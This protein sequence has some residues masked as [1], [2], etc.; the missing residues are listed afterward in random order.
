MGVDA[1]STGQHTMAGEHDHAEAQKPFRFEQLLNAFERIRYDEPGGGADGF[2][3]P[4]PYLHD[5][6][7]ALTAV[8]HMFEHLGSA[9]LFVKRDVL[10]KRDT[11]HAVFAADPA[12]HETV[13]Q[14]VE[15]ELRLGT[16]DTRSGQV[17][18]TRNL[19]RMMWCVRFLYVLMRDVARTHDG[20]RR[21]L[22]DCVW[23][24]YCDALR[25]H[26]G[27]VIVTAV[28]AAL[29]FLPSEETF[30]QS[31]GVEAAR[32]GEYLTRIEQCF[33]PLVHRLYAYYE[34]RDLLRLP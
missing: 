28:R 33:A 4:L 7:Q 31:M 18:G 32:R 2:P 10:E 19:L 12:G 27:T 26:H 23:N 30:L 14:M 16:A 25:E 5:F 22:R 24:A 20:T 11:L 21:N 15:E 17:G 3:Q 1:N 9:F 13:R 29:W 34:A 6:V 8:S